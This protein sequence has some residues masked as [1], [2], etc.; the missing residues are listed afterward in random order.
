V[1]GF[2]GYGDWRSANGCQ[3]TVDLRR[4]LWTP[5]IAVLR[6]RKL[7]FRSSLEKGCS[8]REDSAPILLRYCTML[9]SNH[10]TRVSPAASLRRRAFS[11]V[12]MIAATALVAGTLAPA[13][14]V[15]RDA[16]AASRESARRHLLANYAVQALE[17]N[18]G[19]TMQNWTTGT[20]TGNFAADG[21]PAIRYVLTRSDDLADGG[22]DDR[23]MH[24]QVT[25]FDDVNG[26]AT[27]DANEIAVRF[28]TKVAKLLTYQNEP[29]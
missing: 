1:D 3:L 23:L 2:D 13:L 14:A 8:R 5:A 10:P 12:E 26:N 25:V 20:A 15:M 24:V 4:L 22:I 18:A 16:M 19:A 21:H 7:G 17:Q 6:G 28:R 11:L 27:H 9:Y 29:N